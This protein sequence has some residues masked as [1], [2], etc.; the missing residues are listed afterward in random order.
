M[1]FNFMKKLNIT[2]SFSK[3]FKTSHEF[4]TTIFMPSIL[5]IYFME[6]LW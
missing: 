2:M 3:Y 5:K 1:K 6:Y 4:M